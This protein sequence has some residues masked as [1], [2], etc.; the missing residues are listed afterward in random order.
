ML[1]NCSSIAQHHHTNINPK[2]TD[3]DTLALRLLRRR[4]L[5]PLIE[6]IGTEIEKRGKEGESD[7]PGEV[8]MITDKGAWS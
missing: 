7:L 4:S 6:I 2:S 5:P 3:T 1:R 8:E